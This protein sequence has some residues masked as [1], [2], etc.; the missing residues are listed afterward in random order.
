M[1]L[2]KIQPFTICCSLIL[3]GFLFQCLCL[4]SISVTL[5]LCLALFLFLSHPFSHSISLYCVSLTLF[6]FLSHTI[7]LFVFT[8]LTFSSQ[9]VSSQFL[10]RWS[11]WTKWSPNSSTIP[12]LPQITKSQFQDSQKLGKMLSLSLDLGLG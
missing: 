3:T 12:I 1:E 7:S 2:I 5:S 6:R 9:V 11:Q 4:S 8:F 10:R